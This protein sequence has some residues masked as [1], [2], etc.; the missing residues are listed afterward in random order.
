[1]K[2]QAWIDSHPYLAG[3]AQF[4]QSIDD[5]LDS[6]V[7]TDIESTVD[8]LVGKL[9]VADDDAVVRLL[10]C[11]VMRRLNPPRLVDNGNRADCPTCGA[12]ASL[13]ALVEDDGGRRR[14]LACSC[15]HTTW[16]FKR[17]GCPYCGDESP[18]SVLQIDED[19]DHRIDACNHCR[20][21]LK[22]FT[23]KGDMS[24]FLA[25]WP[26]LHLDVIARERGYERGGTTLYDL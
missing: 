9:D 10:T 21:Y 25:D 24:L 4:E 13:A 18:Q 22:T 23:G 16:Q 11:H 26:T 3:I 12:T 5:T 1:M 7:V 6:M 15:C 8:E 2:Y 17:V 20:A 19:S 14:L